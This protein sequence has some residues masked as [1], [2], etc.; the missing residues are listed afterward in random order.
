MRAARCVWSR[1]RASPYVT[2]R[3]L[4]IPMSNRHF[5]FDPS[6]PG[7]VVTFQTEDGTEAAAAG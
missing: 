7:Q 2:S 1:A 3:G 5:K 4:T 6:L